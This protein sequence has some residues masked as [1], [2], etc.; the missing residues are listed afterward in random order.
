MIA[1]SL[2]IRFF[3]RT[4]FVAVLN[5]NVYLSYL[6]ENIM[7]RKIHVSMVIGNLITMSVRIHD[8]NVHSNKL[9]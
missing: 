5:T 3:F 2:G 6:V 9:K 7:V 1:G 8:P 4:E